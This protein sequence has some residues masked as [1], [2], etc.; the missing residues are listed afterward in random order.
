MHV[1]LDIQTRACART[2]ENH[3]TLLAAFRRVASIALS[4]NHGQCEVNTAAQEDECAFNYAD[5]LTIN[6]LEG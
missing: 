2:L 6:S 5:V 3:G 1:L 4:A